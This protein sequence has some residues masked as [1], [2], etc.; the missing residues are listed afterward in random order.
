MK[1]D[2][3]IAAYLRLR[4]VKAVERK[5]YE[6]KIAKVESSMVKIEAAILKQMQESGTQSFKTEAGTAYQTTRETTS[7][8]DWDAFF[9]YVKDND[10]WELLER[11]A[12]KVALRGFKEANDGDLPPGVN[13][14]EERVVN[15]RKPA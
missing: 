2:E 1:I 7:M 14:S 4:E 15:F 11:R 12:S 5:K 8:A 13:W 3:L 6:E 9:N 10:S